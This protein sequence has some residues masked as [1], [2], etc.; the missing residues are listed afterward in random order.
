VAGPSPA[1]FKARLDGAL[2]NLVWW[3]MSLLMAGGLEPDDLQDPFQHKPFY[4]SITWRIKVADANLLKDQ[5]T[6]FTM[7]SSSKI[8]YFH[9]IVLLEELVIA[10]NQRGTAVPLQAVR[11]DRSP[12]SGKAAWLCL[13]QPVPPAASENIC[14]EHRR[15]DLVTCEF[16]LSPV[17]FCGN[18][19]VPSSRGSCQ[20]GT[21]SGVSRSQRFSM[22]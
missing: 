3:K 8:L 13:L 7:N 6:I 5:A 9:K 2:S 14:P 10:E 20:L 1:V 18:K 22:A 19:T 17:P 21:K 12:G 4:D 11:A 15:K 16:A